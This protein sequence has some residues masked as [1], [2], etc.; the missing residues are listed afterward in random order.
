MDK[1]A[2]QEPLGGET[3]QEQSF[4]IEGKEVPFSE[5]DPEV[6]K[7][8]Y[9]SHT[10][11]D[12][13]RGES[14]RRS[15]QASEQRREAETYRGSVDKQLQDYDTMVNYLN[16]HQDLVAQ[17]NDYVARERGQGQQ[18]YQQAQ[19]GPQAQQQVPR[20]FNPEKDEMLKRLEK[21]E[22]GLG[23]EGRHRERGIALGKLKESYRD[24][25]EKKFNDYFMNKT[26]NFDNLSDLY[27]LVHLAMVGTEHIAAQAKQGTELDQGATGSGK[28]EPMI[29]IPSGQ[30]AMQDVFNR[31]AKEKGIA[32]Y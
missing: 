17:I 2:M 7:G 4:S 11:M 18:G 9:D 22:T 26:G 10:N 21:I 3:P 13:F 32:D 15:Q 12:K 8:W 14:T 24:F 31:I 30:N 29:T 28:V 16:A 25:D 1:I 5:L 27:N 19:R 20:Q 6:V 23:E